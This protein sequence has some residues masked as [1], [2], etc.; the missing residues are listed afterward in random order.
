MRDPLVLN[1]AS[2]R[3]LNMQSSSR[4]GSPSSSDVKSEKYAEEELKDFTESFFL[5]KSSKN[6][7]PT[8]EDYELR[9]RE[10]S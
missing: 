9:N 7:L 3:P 10:I 1:V 8:F 4:L 2:S 5:N 6:Q